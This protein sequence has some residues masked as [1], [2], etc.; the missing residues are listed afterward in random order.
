MDAKLF[1]SE[2]ERARLVRASKE[3]EARAADAEARAASA[4]ARVSAAEAR[5]HEAAARGNEAQARAEETAQRIAALSQEI[6]AARHAGGAARSEFDAQ[7]AAAH[8]ERARLEQAVQAA[9]ARADEAERARDE[10]AKAAVVE[11][12]HDEEPI[13]SDARFEAIEAD[14]TRMELAWQDAES[15]AAEA[16]R[17]RDEAAKALRMLQ[18]KVAGKKKGAQYKDVELTAMLD[19]TAPPSDQAAVRRAVRYRF[20]K[21]VE[22]RIDSDVGELADLSVGGVQLLCPKQP[23]VNHLV[24]VTIGS[25]KSGIPCEGRIVWAWLEPHSQGRKLRYRA[26]ISFTKMNEA[27]IEAFIAKESSKET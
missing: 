3:A 15:R 10:M 25:G 14:R 24:T 27:A 16:M 23:E 7:L 2:S 12:S 19:S 20:P 11:I 17:Q 5:A 4:D 18:L 13:T 6:E 9:Q 26:G 1:A 21:T 22:V 8:A